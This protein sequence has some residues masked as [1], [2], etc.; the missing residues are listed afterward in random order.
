MLAPGLHRFA[1]RQRIA[2]VR[3]LAVDWSGK[4]KRAEEYLWF[5]DVRDGRL[6]DLRNGF[7]RERLAER[8]VALAEEDARTVVGLDFAFSFPRWWCD[9]RG[10]TNGPEV[11]AAMAE[12]GEALLAACEEPFWGRPGK[13]NPHPVDRL[14]RRTD[15]D[16]GMGAAKSI[17][18]IGGAGAVGTG[19]IRGMPQLLT[20]AEQDVQIWPFS[21]DGW[22]RVVEIYPR[23]LTGQVRKSSWTERHAYLRTR[24][25]DQPTDL[26]E[27][28]AGSEDA[29]DAAVSGLMM[30]AH[31]DQ[32]HALTQASDPDYAIEGRI[33]R[34]E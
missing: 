21:A 12:E 24:F 32:F 14:Y 19:S 30:G 3:V 16:A 33:W 25:P 28:A 29:F 1:G 26:L 13:P 9:Q 22:P 23:A 20:L 10:W 18:Q 11:W 2:V 15:R 8:L 5:A 7:T 31:E 17:F 34:P 4:L 27:R 6:V